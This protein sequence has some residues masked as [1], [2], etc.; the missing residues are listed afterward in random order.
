VAAGVWRNDSTGDGC[1]WAITSKSGDIE[2]NHYG[3]G[4][5][6]MYV[7]ATGYQV[8]MGKKCGTWT[9]LGQ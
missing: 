3:L 6:T 9:Y 5:G 8:E 7:P 4:G 2:N 1:Y